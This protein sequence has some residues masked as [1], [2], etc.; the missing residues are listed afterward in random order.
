MQNAGSL[1]RLMPPMWV[2]LPGLV[3]LSFIG[4]ALLFATNIPFYEDYDVII[5]YLVNS[6]QSFFNELFGWHGHRPA[7]ARLLAKLSLLSGHGVDLR[8]LIACGVLFLIGVCAVMHRSVVEEHRRFILALLC[9]SLFS[10][11]HRYAIMWSLNAV[12][13]YGVLLL[14][15][16]SFY[17]FSK[18][19]ALAQAGGVVC[20]F[21]AAYAWSNGLLVLPIL[22]VW[23]IADCRD[24][25]G[26]KMVLVCAIAC[27]VSVYLFFVALPM[28]SSSGNFLPEMIEHLLSG[29]GS[30][31][32][33]GDAAQFWLLGY[34]TATAGWV[35]ALP[36]AA[37]IGLLIN[38]YFI[39]LIRCRYYR[40]NSVVF[41]TYLFCLMSVALIV[42]F[43][44]ELGEGW[45]RAPRYQVFTLLVNALIVISFLE[46]GF[47]R[48]V[49]TRW[50]RANF[51]KAL[52]AV[53]TLFWLASLEHVEGMYKREKELTQELKAWR[54]NGQPALA[55][56]N[57]EYAAGLLEKAIAAGLYTLPPEVVAQDEED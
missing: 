10:I 49:P 11:T 30:E 23:S 14:A 3:A 22:L 4:P 55:H 47:E 24:R 15:V 29:H 21:A 45:A 42:M 53:F 43:R 33:F 6:Q 37:F 44:L 27:A 28:P 31:R 12:G 50:L 1:A 36:L 48:Y 26:A 51:R 16:L 13:L 35:D 54:I 19:H 5:Q 40:K 25:A 56:S 57:Q 18:R 7:L 17:L 52:T 2:A 20:G 46:L 32:T 34:L 9:M 41:Y 8:F 39:V 38:L